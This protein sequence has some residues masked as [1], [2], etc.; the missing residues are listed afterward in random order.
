MADARAPLAGLRVVEMARILAGPWIGQTLADLGAD[1]I[2]VESPA[3]DDTRK[4]GPPFIDVEG[5]NTAAYFHCCN[6]GK[7]SIVLDFKTEDGQRTL[8]RLIA[9]CDVF[10][11]N[12]KV[13]G[14][15]KH[16][17]D[18]DAVRER[19][20]AVI[21]CSVTGFGQTGP[22][23]RRAGYDFLVQGMGG[24]MSVTGEPDGLPQKMGVAFS[25]IFTAL[26]GVIGI[27]AALAE[28]Q[29]TGRG[30]HIDL[31]LYD[32]IVAVMANQA[33][34]QLIG[35]VTP[36]RLG[37]AHPNIVPYQVFACA[38]GHIIA[39]VGNDGQFERFCRLLG[40]S[41]LALDPAYATNPARVAHRDQLVPLLVD[42]IAPW[43]KAELLE[44]M[45]RAVVP[46]APINTLA[47]VF[48][49]PQ[50]VSR[51]LRI[52]PQGVPG[53]RTPLQFSDA[54]LDLSRRSPNLGE[55]TEEILGEIAP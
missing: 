22:Y 30:Q 52:E 51:G 54:T 29:R 21:Y 31:S 11:E 37:N 55:H 53:V 32:S 8:E 18:H 41:E 23:A 17:F 40:C 25:D 28:R 3:G 1:V 33:S 42:A 19:H 10:I 16:G 12:F 13:G 5:E 38:D 48:V 2:K 43:R 44:A 20:P 24:I 9:G 27:Q 36:N 34:N 47:D 7:R 46:G 49:D 15:A 4:W 26:Y 45:E 6:R 35:G 50:I 39:A 14:L